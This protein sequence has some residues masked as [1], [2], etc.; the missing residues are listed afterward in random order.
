MKVDHIYIEQRQIVRNADIDLR[1]DKPHSALKRVY[2]NLAITLVAGRNG[3]GKS[4]LLS[5]IAQIFHHLERSPGDIGGRFSL[6][7]RIQHAQEGELC[8]NLY[9][10]RTKGPIRLQ[11][12]GRFDKRIVRDKAGKRA[13]DDDAIAYADIKQFLP[14]NVI[15]SGFSMRG[16]YPSNRPPNYVGDRRLRVFDMSALYGRNHF[17]FPPFSPG[18][19]RLLSLALRGSHGVAMLESMLGA[20]ITGRVLVKERLPRIGKNPAMWQN[21]SPA[22]AEREVRGEIWLNDLELRGSDGSQFTL[23]KM[24]SGQKFLLARILSVLGAIEKHSIVILEEPEMHLDPAWS[25]QVISLL[26]IFFSHYAAHLFIATHSF[27]LLNSVPTSWILMADAGKFSKLPA[28]ARTLLAN[29]SALA[30]QLYESTPHMVELAIRSEMKEASAE[31]LRN[32]FGLLGESAL[33][34][35]VFLKLREQDPDFQEE[36]VDEDGEEGDEIA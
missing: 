35:D 31:K 34:Y 15:V 17:K 19:A 3:S 30:G 33:R 5:F 9:R 4:S 24:S 20:R 16:E 26:I 12:G 1:V 14:T 23:E 13:A 28:G 10:S 2:G 36:A 7:Y 25:R 27:S 29:E 32:L 21:F 6:R 18:L 8:C 11:V 22:L